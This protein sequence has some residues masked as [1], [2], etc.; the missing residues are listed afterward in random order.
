[1]ARPSHK[2]TTHI[3][4]QVLSLRLQSNSLTHESQ[5]NKPNEE[6]NDSID[7][8]QFKLTVKYE[9]NHKIITIDTTHK[10]SLN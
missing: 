7:V 9:K 2:N 4:N 10:R 5:H 3:D 6:N 8:V 1:M